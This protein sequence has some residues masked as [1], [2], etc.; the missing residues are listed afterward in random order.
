MYRLV[1]CGT[2]E[3]KMYARQVWKECVNKQVV[4][5]KT[6]TKHF[7]RDDLKDLFMLQD[8]Q[9]STMRHNISVG[10]GNWVDRR[11]FVFR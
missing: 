10:A 5:K 8:P 4:E 2:V 1:T 7:T 6:I 11:S 3:E 9:H